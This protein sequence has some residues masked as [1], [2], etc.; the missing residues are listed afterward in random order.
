[1]IFPEG[2]RAPRDSTL[3]PFKKGGFML[4][5]ETGFPIVPL[6]SAAAADIL[7][8]GSL[9]ARGGR[10]S[11]S[12]SGRRSRWPGVDRDELMRR[13]RAFMHEHVDDA[14]PRRRRRPRAAEAV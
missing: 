13:V 11:R 9:A 7:P 12:S 3:L 5:L 8:R 6:A 4:A 2:T 10:R 1:M 14:G